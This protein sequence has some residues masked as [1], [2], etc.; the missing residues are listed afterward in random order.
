M[1]TLVAILL[2]IIV[3]LYW[4]LV[5]TEDLWTD[6]SL[7]SFHLRG[8]VAALK[9]IDQARVCFSDPPGKKVYSKALLFPE[10]YGNLKD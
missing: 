1:K 10:V 6:A 8:E 4:S 5:R 7:E 2:L 9:H 3:F